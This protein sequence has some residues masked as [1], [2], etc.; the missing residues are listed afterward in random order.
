[1]WC[2][3]D[4]ITIDVC[5]DNDEI[6]ADRVDELDSFLESI[7]PEDNELEIQIEDESDIS[8]DENI[9]NELTVF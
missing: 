7:R 8:I 3:T 2:A 5:G 4:I 9:L 1:M 6:I